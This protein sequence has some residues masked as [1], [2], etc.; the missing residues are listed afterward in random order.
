MKK[1]NLVFKLTTAVCIFVLS[2]V[3]PL[4]V[5]ADA[6]SSVLPAGSFYKRF[7][8]LIGNKYEITLHLTK[9]DNE[10]NGY[11][12]YRGRNIPLLLEGSVDKDGKWKLKETTRD[13][14]ET[15]F[16]DITSLQGAD[17][18][19]TWQSIDKSKNLPFAAREEYNNS[20]MAFRTYQLKTSAPLFL[21]TRDPKIEINLFYLYPSA[22]KDGKVLKDVRE[23]LFAG[24]KGDPQKILENISRGLVDDYRQEN[25]DIYDPQS[26]WM[27]MWQHTYGISLVCNDM[28]ILTFSFY[29]Y[30]YTGGAHGLFGDD[31]STIDLKTGKK[32][33]L[34][35]IFVPGYREKLGKIMEAKVRKADNIAPGDSLEDHGYFVHTITPGDTFYVAPDG[36]GFYFNIYE[37]R[38]YA[39]GPSDIFLS[40]KEIKQF[41]KPNSPV[42][43]LFE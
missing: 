14:Q 13:G 35:D 34:D 28:N 30:D 41:I 33:G 21:K 15:G 39:F 43:R 3:L 37:I 5:S 31:F 38:P 10:L 25:Q 42:R 11:Y 36:I 40:F 22:F 7:E 27:F 24:K 26:D 32:L 2:G 6:G 8:G 19:G 16:F 18:K 17:I 12:Y 4:P 29:Y 9:H 20:S 23:I 1:I